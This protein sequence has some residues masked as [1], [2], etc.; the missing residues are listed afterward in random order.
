MFCTM[1]MQ[2]RFPGRT[3]T[4][5]VSAMLLVAVVAPLL[6][7][8]LPFDQLTQPGSTVLT[9]LDLL[10]PEPAFLS[11]ET[12]LPFVPIGVALALTA[13]AEAFRRGRV[14]EDELEGTV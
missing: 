13:A 12:T 6:A 9:H 1:S 5:V 11:F 7:R 4:S 14:L 10:G 2:L 8:G 3:G